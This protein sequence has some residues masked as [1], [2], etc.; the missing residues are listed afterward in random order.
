MSE[1]EYKVTLLDESFSGK[2][3]LYKKLTTITTFYPKNISTIGLDKKT[4]NLNFD[5]NKKG[6]I[7]Y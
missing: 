3:I 5:V 7:N 6:I 4:I 1:I 2:T